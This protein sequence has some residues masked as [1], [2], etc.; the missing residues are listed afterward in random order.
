VTIC[1]ANTQPSLDTSTT[2][3]HFQVCRNLVEACQRRRS[4][5]STGTLCPSGGCPW[6]ITSTVCVNSLHFTA[7]SSD[8]YCMD[9]ERTP[10]SPVSVSQR[11]MHHHQ[12]CASCLPRC[13]CKSL[14][15]AAA[16]DHVTVV[17]GGIQACTEDGTVPWIIRQRTL[18]ATVA[19][20][21]V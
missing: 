2:T 8:L 6:S 17:T 9:S 4:N 19:L 7:S 1:L 13:R 3:S 18:P 16:G 12:Q 11:T 15:H 10:R 5:I 14:E 21:L 20:T